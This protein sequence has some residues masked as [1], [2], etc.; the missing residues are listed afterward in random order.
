MCQSFDPGHGTCIPASCSA[1]SG[2]SVTV[3]CDDSYQ[4]EGSSSV[5]CLP[6]GSW[7]KATPHCAGNNYTDIN[8][9]NLIYLV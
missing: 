5:V 6:S 1:M 8:T 4:L 2:G 7:D 9:L 3:H